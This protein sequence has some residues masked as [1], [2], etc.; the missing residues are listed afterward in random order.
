MQVVAFMAIKEY[1]L[2]V[3][4]LVEIL[5]KSKSFG[6]IKNMVGFAATT[7]CAEMWSGYGVD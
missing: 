7:N 5:K 6:V 2:L 1:K 3:N 4:Y